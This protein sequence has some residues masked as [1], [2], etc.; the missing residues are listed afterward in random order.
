[1]AIDE[2]WMDGYER[3][4]RLFLFHKS[5]AGLVGED[6]GCVVDLEGRSFRG[7]LS[8]ISIFIDG[9]VPVVVLYMIVS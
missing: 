6:F 5:P 4:M 2:G 7:G 8:E 9:D 3:E 1:M